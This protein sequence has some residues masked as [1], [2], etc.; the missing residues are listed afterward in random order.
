MDSLFAGRAIHVLAVVFW[1]GGVAVVTT[2]LLPAARRL[3]APEDRVAFFE[4]IEHGFAVQSRV[5]TL[6]AAA[7]G[8]YLVHQLDLW[9]RFLHADYW[10]MHAMV[11]IWV[12]FTLVLF[13]LEPLFLHRWFIERARRE[14]EAAFRLVSRFHWVML[15]LS[16]LTV[17]GA[18]A[19][20]HGYSL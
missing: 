3:K 5:T 12:V 2:I 20:S 14:P 11:A 18:A 16:V 19:G 8:F 17:A 13:V 7:S 6:I 4:E 10:W 1:I 15:I 9:R